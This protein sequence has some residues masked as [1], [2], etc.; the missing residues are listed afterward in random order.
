MLL[1]ARW[2]GAG[3]EA[4]V[5]GPGPGEH[6]P[7]PFG[8][9]GR[10]LLAPVLPRTRG[11]GRGRPGCRRRPGPGTQVFF[12][13]TGPGGWPADFLLD[14]RVA[15]REP[16][17][18]AVDHVALTQPFDAFD[19]AGLFY[20]SVLGWRRRPSEYAVPFGIVRS[21]AM[22][23]QRA[24]RL[25]SA[26]P[27]C[28]AVTGPPASPPPQSIAFATDDVVATARACAAAG[29][30]AGRGAGQLSRRPRRPPRSRSAAARR[31]AGAGCS[32]TRTRT[33]GHLHL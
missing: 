10:A 27:C 3:E 32:T 5:V 12:A 23:V 20:R 21:R 1:N 2:S 26:S 18:S 25:A 8:R 33:A 9:A 29:A 28:A 7:R 14:R 22:T 19:E 6:G 11:A 15:A 16:A 24:V 17:S 31:H 30:P 4:E 13:R